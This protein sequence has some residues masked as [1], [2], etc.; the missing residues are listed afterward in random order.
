MFSESSRRFDGPPGTCLNDLCGGE[1]LCDG[2]DDGNVCTNETC[3]WIGECFRR[4]VV[5]CGGTDECPSTCDPA[6]GC[7][8]ETAGEPC[9]VSKW[10]GNFATGYWLCKFSG[11]CGEFGECLFCDFTSNGM[12]CI[13]DGLPGVCVFGV[14]GENLCEDV[15][16]DDSLACTVDTCDFRNGTCDFRNVCNDHDDCTENICNPLDGLCDFT[17]PVEDGTKC[18]IWE[19]FYGLGTCED[20]VCVGPCDPASN[21]ELPCPIY[22]YGWL[23][24]CPSVEFCIDTE[25]RPGCPGER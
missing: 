2:C 11:W 25:E 15:V 17:T 5:E 19:P 14:C 7:I 6:R 18:E 16:C 13:F 12:A 8:Y 10:C 1:H 20:G 9:T 23:E 3:N 24:C 21:Q 4:G 22:G